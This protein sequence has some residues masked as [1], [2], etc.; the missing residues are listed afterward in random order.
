MVPSAPTNQERT[1][2][3]PTGELLRSFLA[4]IRL[5]L[6]R[7]AD[8]ARLEVLDKWERLRIAGGLLTG[9]VVAALL[10]LGTL[11]AAAV[12]L[13]AIALPA[14]GAAM[15]VGAVLAILASVLFVVGRSRVRS[16]GPLAPTETIE[17]AREDVAWMRHETEQL[18]TTGSS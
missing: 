5:M 9:A 16:V 12:L 18:R 8:L 1:H 7:E 11:T 2:E 6:E 15:L 3:A 17:T 10:A 13:V 14:W 4:D